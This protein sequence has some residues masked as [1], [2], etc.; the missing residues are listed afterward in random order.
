[1]STFSKAY[2]LPVHWKPFFVFADIC[3]QGASWRLRY[4]DV[5]VS[6]WLTGRRTETD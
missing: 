5:D 6:E 2:W 3:G 4:L 1:M